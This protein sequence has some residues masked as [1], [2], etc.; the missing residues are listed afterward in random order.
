MMK[1]GEPFS[2]KYYNELG[3]VKYKFA[4]SDSTIYVNSNASV[5]AKYRLRAPPKEIYTLHRK[6]AGAFLFNINLNSEINAINMWAAIR[7]NRENHQEEEERKE[8]KLLE[9]HQ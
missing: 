4:E 9:E 2:Q 6:L 3:F 5:W 7:Q 1:V 8:K